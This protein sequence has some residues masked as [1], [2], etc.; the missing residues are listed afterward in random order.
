MNLADIFAFLSREKRSFIRFTQAGT[1]GKAGR[2]KGE[3]G[4]ENG[5]KSKGIFG[6]SIF[7]SF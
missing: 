3:S 1:D 4:Q 5:K 6:W 2:K 7:M